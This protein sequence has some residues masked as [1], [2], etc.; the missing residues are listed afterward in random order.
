MSSD[1][2]DS[3]LEFPCPVA[4]K[5]MGRLNS[6]FTTHITELVTRHAGPLEKN[7][8]QTRTSR[9]GNYVSVTITIMAQSKQQLDDLYT[10]LSADEYVLM[11][12]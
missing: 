6:S 4:I 2:L 1:K 10:E 3:L 8:V 12:L 9:N 7:A 5:A 11:A